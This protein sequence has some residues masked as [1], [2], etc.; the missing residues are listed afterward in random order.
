M[1]ELLGGVHEVR[2][3]EGKRGVWK[4]KIE[5]MGAERGGGGCDVKRR[6]RD[7]RRL[8][9]ERKNRT[10]GCKISV[11]FLFVVGNCFT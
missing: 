10:K 3:R 1:R 2:G 4:E 9:R 6:E 7:S 5:E 8:K 11:F